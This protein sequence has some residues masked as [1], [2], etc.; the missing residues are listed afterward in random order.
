MKKIV[1]SVLFLLMVVILAGLTMVYFKGAKSGTTTLEELRGTDGMDITVPPQEGNPDDASVE[2]AEYL[3][4]L[5]YEEIDPQYIVSKGKTLTDLPFSYTLD[6]WQIT[7][8]GPSTEIEL[9]DSAIQCNENGDILNGYSYVLTDLTVENLK[10]SEVTQY[11]WARFQVNVRGTEKILTGEVEEIMYLDT[12]TLKE[13]RKN[14]LRETFNAK[15]VKKIRLIFIVSDDLLLN[16]QLYLKIYPVMET[17]SE[18]DMTRW[19]VMN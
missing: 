18:E 6:S 12:N 2:L 7:K 8:T 4:K 5:M 15:E 11:I 14:L 3:S 19:I 16:G 9:E 1:I 13:G 10:D 17:N